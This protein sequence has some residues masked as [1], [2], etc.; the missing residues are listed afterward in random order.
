LPS[1]QVRNWATGQL[2]NLATPRTRQ[3]SCTPPARVAFFIRKTLAHGPIRFAV[4]PRASA[5]A[6][7]SDAA[8]STGPGGEFLRRSATGFFLAT[9]RNV[10]AAELPVSHGISGTPFFK[11]VFDGSRRGYVFLGLTIL[12]VILILL[13]IGV[14]VNKGPAGWVNVIL[15]LALIATPIIMT[16]Q[17][18]KKIKEQ[19]EKERAA[20]EETERRHREMLASY[21]AALERLRREPSD[22]A[23]DAA[24]AERQRLELPYEIW[25]AP[26]KRTVLQ[27][28]FEA[29][30]RLGT[31]RAKEVDALMTRA[32]G[33]V[34]LTP[35]DELGV[36]LDLYRVI[37][38][39]LLADDRIGAA[40][41]A[42][43]LQ[44]RK[45]FDIWDRDVPV[46]SKAADEFHRL[47]GITVENLPRTQCGLSLGFH[48][49]CIH[50][51]KGSSLKHVREKVD[52]RKVVKLVPHEPCVLHVTNKR[53]VVE[54]KK[55]VEVPLPKI[56]DVELDLDANVITIRTARGMK[57][58]EVQLE[59]PVYTGALIDIAASLNERPRGF[60]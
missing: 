37:L 56:D 7:D 43:L 33:A 27:I 8:L 2:G 57:P 21:N 36:K 1:C 4:Q 47:R 52:G 48:E 34:G 51:T 45:G 60:A 30:A 31:T 58:L 55:P 46:E 29:L 15:G 10:G 23:I 3:P 19:E 39:H 41:S 5:D 13:G 53:I 50:S 6:I 20:R 9:S 38:W 49:Y 25:S 16:A 26:A 14:I 12:G 44:F 18:R 11:S 32:S 54:L 22:A 59:D 40:Q 17:Q 24:D 35:A 42:A 28:G